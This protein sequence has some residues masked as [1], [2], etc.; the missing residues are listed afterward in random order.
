MNYRSK[1]W[2]AMMDRTFQYLFPFIEK[3]TSSGR[4]QVK[5]MSY[6]YLAHSSIALVKSYQS[7]ITTQ[8]LAWITAK[9]LIKQESLSWNTLR[10]RGGEPLGYFQNCSLGL[11]PVCLLTSNLFVRACITCSSHVE[12]HILSHILSQWTLQRHMCIVDPL[13]GPSHPSGSE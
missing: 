12:R 6:L 7:V 10:Y 3:M 5:L 2:A 1:L 11:C 9:S 8:M 4:K 13:L